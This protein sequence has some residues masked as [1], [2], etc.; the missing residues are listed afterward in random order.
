MLFI[1]GESGTGKE[2]LAHAFHKASPQRGGPFVA[3]N[4]AAIPEGI[5]ERLLFGA[6]KGAFSGVVADSEGYLAAASG[7]TL[8]LDEVADM[9]PV[10]QGKL[11]RVIDT[12]ELLP[13]GATRARKVQFQVCTATHK[14]LRALTQEGKFRADL[15]FRIG[16]PQIAVPPLRERREEIPWLMKA[17]LRA[18]PELLL[19]VPLVEACLL[20]AWPGNVREILAETHSAAF[21]AQAAKSDTVQVEHLSASA[22]AAMAAP[23]RPVAEESARPAAA[24][25]ASPRPASAPPSR[26]QVLAALL[27]A[28]GNVSAAAR[29][30]QVH[31]TQFRRLLVRHNIDR[32]KLLRLAE[33]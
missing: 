22:G 14:D 9:D 8:F 18:Q 30:L 3:V 5:A 17:A 26:A 25:A 19:S 2:S 16:L 27:E 31:R 23:L 10:V 33:P 24:S 13:L 1:S 28:K 20:R 21:K 32:E 7:G 15:Y 12:G 29:A 4:C 11:L 6:L